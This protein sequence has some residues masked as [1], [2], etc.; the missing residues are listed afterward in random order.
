MSNFEG[1]LELKSPL[2]KECWD[3]LTD[4]ELENTERMWFTTPNGKRVEY[5][6][7]DVLDKRRDA[8]EREADYQYANVNADVAKGM[9]MAIEIIDKQAK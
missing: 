1:T 8:I 5:I 4:V 6:K 3:K 9:Y 2:T 7:A